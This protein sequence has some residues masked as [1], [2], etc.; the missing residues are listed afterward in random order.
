MCM[1]E[2]VTIHL[3]MNLRIPLLFHFLLGSVVFAQG[4]LQTFTKLI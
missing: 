2:L 4:A 1:E 3:S